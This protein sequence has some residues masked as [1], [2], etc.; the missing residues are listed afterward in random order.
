MNP[1]TLSRMID[2]FNNQFYVFNRFYLS[3]FAIHITSQSTVADHERKSQVICHFYYNQ[4]HSLIRISH[5]NTSYSH[6]LDK[7]AYWLHIVITI[8]FNQSNYNLNKHT[9][10]VFTFTCMSYLSVKHGYLVIV[11]VN[12]TY[13]TDTYVLLFYCW[14]YTFPVDVLNRPKKVFT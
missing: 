11:S 10:L 7:Q 1:E 3:F 2:Y 5:T 6:T 13:Y 9:W 4:M 14:L 8:Q 12:I